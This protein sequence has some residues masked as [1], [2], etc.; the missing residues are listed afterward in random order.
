MPF[1]IVTMTHPDGDGWGLHVAAHVRY[2]QALVRAGELRASGPLK[3]A[4]KRAGF[5]IFRAASRARVDALISNDPFASEGLI[6]TSTV[7]EWDPLFGTFAEESSGK[8]PGL[9]TPG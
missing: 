1:F 6:E 5:L 4:P 2:L 3:G 8:L 9:G 7:T